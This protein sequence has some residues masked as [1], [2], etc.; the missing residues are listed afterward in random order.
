MGMFQLG[1]GTA[2]L[3]YGGAV[4]SIAALSMLTFATQAA[5]HEVR[6]AI[7]DLTLS[8][9]SA[10]FEVILALEALVAGIDLAGVSDTDTAPQAE[11]YDALRALPPA[12]L[13]AE[14]ET[15]WPGLRDGFVF[16]FGDTRVTP[17]LAEVNVAEVGNLELPRDSQLV[18]DIDLPA[19][20]AP[21][22]AGWVAEYGPLIVRQIS[23]D[24]DGGYSGYLTE[25]RL[26]DPIER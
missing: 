9:D 10:R 1:K 18:L 8:G 13:R 25:G 17:R 4:S 24:D 2:K 15:A 3:A 21:L 23:D 14:F 6:P 5:A 19:G 22:R 7:A 12:K 20:D 16:E 11:A 26:T